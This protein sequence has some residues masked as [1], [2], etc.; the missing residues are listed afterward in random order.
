M[1]HK[2]YCGQQGY[3]QA[4]DVREFT[5][6]AHRWIVEQN[7]AC[8]GRCR[9][10]AKVFEVSEPIQRREQSSELSCWILPALAGASEEQPSWRG[11]RRGMWSFPEQPVR[12]WQGS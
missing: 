2:G 5:I 10:P 1:L 11:S 9:H 4:R 8:K 12:A 6:P 3:S 7:L